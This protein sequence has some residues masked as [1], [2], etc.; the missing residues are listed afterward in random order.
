MG[1]TVIAEETVKNEIADSTL[2]EKLRI[3]LLVGQVR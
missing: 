2:L 1:R 3:G